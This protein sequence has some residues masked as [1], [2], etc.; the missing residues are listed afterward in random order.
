MKLLQPGKS[1]GGHLVLDLKPGTM[2]KGE[3]K[4]EIWIPFWIVDLYFW[5]RIQFKIGNLF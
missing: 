2:A 4:D 3:K 5:F 1:Q